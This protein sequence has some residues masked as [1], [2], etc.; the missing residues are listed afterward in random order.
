FV[1]VDRSG[2]V[3][4]RIGEPMENLVSASLS[5]D[6]RRVALHRGGRALGIWILDLERGV[7]SL[8][9][10]GG[11]HPTWAPDGSRIAFAMDSG[12]TGDIYVQPMIGGGSPQSPTPVAPAG[13]PLGKRWPSDWSADGRYILSTY[14]LKNNRDIWAVPTIG[15]EKPF[16]VVRGEF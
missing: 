16:P 8:F 10:N 11:Y 13:D 2:K 14:D 4:Q 15:N 12:P 6:G 7:L 3:I 1:W 9:S 5:P